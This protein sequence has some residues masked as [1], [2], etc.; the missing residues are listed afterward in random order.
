M[1]AQCTKCSWFQEISSLVRHTQVFHRSKQS[2]E[3]HEH[4]IRIIRYCAYPGSHR[5]SHADSQSS[6]VHLKKSPTRTWT[7]SRFSSSFLSSTS[8]SS[9]STVC[10]TKGQRSYPYPP[11][12]SAQFS[13]KSL[14]GIVRINVSAAWLCAARCDIKESGEQER[15]RHG[16]GEQCHPSALRLLVGSTVGTLEVERKSLELG[17]AEQNVVR[18]RRKTDDGDISRSA[19]LS[20][21]WVTEGLG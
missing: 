9:T 12:V 13:R 15:R 2:F 14:L 7:S 17:K 4:F 5:F 19:V 10:L 8:I 1:S 16:C 21:G 3:K 20:L 18:I 6:Q 11:S